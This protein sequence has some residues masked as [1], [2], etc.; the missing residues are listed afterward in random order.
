MMD[1]TGC[2]GDVAKLAFKS[3][4]DIRYKQLVK[5]L[6]GLLVT[7]SVGPGEGRARAKRIRDL[8]IRAGEYVFE[9]DGE[10]CTVAVWIPPPV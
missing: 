4:T 3:A 9:K 2:R 5:Q 8:Q 7:V 10:E 1:L 6:K